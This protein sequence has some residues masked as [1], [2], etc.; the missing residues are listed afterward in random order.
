MSFI[1]HDCQV[2]QFQSKEN[3]ITNFKQICFI[4]ISA[5]ESKIQ[6][7]LQ[8]KFICTEIIL[9]WL[10]KLIK[11]E[12]LSVIYIALYLQITI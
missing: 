2:T 1:R 3:Q 10:H 4:I 5:T 6:L 7:K 9:C 11:H 12:T 8:I